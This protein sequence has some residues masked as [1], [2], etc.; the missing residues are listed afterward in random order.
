MKTIVLTGGGTGGHVIPHLALLPYLQEY[1]IEYIG[2]N[3]IERDIITKHNIPFNTITAVKLDRSKKLKNLLIPF[4]LLSSIKQCKKLLKTIKPDVVFSKGGF[5]SIPVVIAA[6]KLKIPIVSHESDL[7]FGL[8]NKII[9]RYCNCMCTTFEQTAKGKSKCVFTGPPIR[10]ELFCGDIAGGKRLT[11]FDNNLPV[12]MVVGGSTGASA[13]NEIVYNALPELTKNYNIIHI[14]GKG[15]LKQQSC[16]NYCQIEYC[17]KIQD[18]LAITDYVVSRAGSNA[19][20]EFAALKKP[21]LLIPLP[22]AASRGDQIQ[23]ANLF[24]KN[25]YA[26]VLYQENASTQTL[27][28]EIEQLEK[29]KDLLITNLSKANFGNATEKI[30]DNIKKFIL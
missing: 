18:L 22:K 25:N 14:V 4:K 10:K 15:K 24:A 2:T 1:K 21:M 6:K 11:N 19:I 28:K 9:Y 26:R 13:L 23:N 8:A 16:K 12:I 27:L 17:D 20:F 29:Y 30:L 5:V 3:G 7:T